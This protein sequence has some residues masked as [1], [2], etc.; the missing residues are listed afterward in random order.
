M[1][2]SRD[3]PSRSGP[4][5]SSGPPSRLAI[6]SL[7][8]TAALLTQFAGQSLPFQHLP[9]EMLILVLCLLAAR[10]ISLASPL[11]LHEAEAPRALLGSA[12]PH[13]GVLSPKDQ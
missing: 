6:E 9:C 10:T 13:R 8:V 7:D 12:L 5:E 1:C 11:L 2:L 3:P 4:I